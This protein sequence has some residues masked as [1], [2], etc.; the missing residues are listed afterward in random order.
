MFEWLAAN[1][2]SVI[3]ALVVLAVM[4]LI[5]WKLA[6]D[7][8]SGKGGCSCGGECSSCGACHTACG[9]IARREAVRKGS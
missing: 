7:K 3:V 6:K 8:K 2:A 4:G 9:G 1:L 5:V